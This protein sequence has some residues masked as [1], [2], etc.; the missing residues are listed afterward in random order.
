MLKLK[1]V[2]KFKYQCLY[3]PVTDNMRK[4]LGIILILVLIAGLLS[5]CGGNTTKTTNPL[6]DGLQIVTTIFPEYDW[7]RNILGDNPARAE[8]T[9]L[10]DNGV[11]LHS[12]QP[13][14]QD[15][16][17][18]SS[19]DLFIYVGGESDVWVEDLLKEVV[20]P[21][22]KVINL[23]EV[24]GSSAKLEE[25]IEGMQG[26]SEEEGEETEYDEHVWLSLN[27]AV[28]FVNIIAEN[29]S[30]I[31]PL[32]ADLYFRNADTYCERL[33]NLD[34]EYRT[35][36]EDTEYKTLVFGDRFPFRYLTDDYGFSYYAAFKGCSAESEASFET[37]SFLAKKMDELKL[38]FILTIE[39]DNHRI[40]QTII[41]NTASKDQ[42]TVQLNSMQSVTSKDV[43]NG[44]D[45]ISIM[46]SNLAKLEKAFNIGKD[47]NAAAGI[48]GTDSIDVD[49]T[50]LSPTMVYAEVYDMLT[51]P[52][53][54]I[55][56]TIKM[57]GE[58]TFYYDTETKQNYFACI[59]KDATAC[60]AQGMEFRLTDDYTYPDDYP[61][62]GDQICVVGT[63]STYKE[64]QYTY[65]TLTDS[66]LI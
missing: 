58:Y 33:R 25:E 37:I 65:C 51:S 62:M 18:I 15:I 66:K 2:F 4:I 61:I 45:Y 36:A 50:A 55:G 60:C 6:S 9:M 20:N 63:F 31:D 17:K 3:S 64:G 38:P 27:N 56:K 46:T 32:N 19:C 12:F 30:D 48:E 49:L 1:T 23:L 35:L 8:L 47:N 34:A 40:A 54:Y 41:D 52:Q 39:G 10:L 42:Q 28:K 29:L 21:N 43:E 7:A 13:T 59:I 26:E 44:A 24:L 11:E 57:D 16:I 14:A 22:M 53:D 5:S